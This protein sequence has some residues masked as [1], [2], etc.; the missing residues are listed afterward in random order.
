MARPLEPPVESWLNGMRVSTR[1][2]LGRE[3]LGPG[4]AI[5]PSR[6]PLLVTVAVLAEVIE[7]GAEISPL[8][9]SVSFRP[10]RTPVARHPLP[11]MLPVLTMVAFLVGE[12]SMPAPQGP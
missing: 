12:V 5:A 4:S 9:A 8:L 11:R 10:I 6:V 2:A 1:L 7:N 3:L